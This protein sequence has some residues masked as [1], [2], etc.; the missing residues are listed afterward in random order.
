MKLCHTWNAFYKFD[1]T[2]KFSHYDLGHRT[3]IVL[4]RSTSTHEYINI[5]VIVH[6]RRSYINVLIIVHTPS[7]W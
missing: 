6:E 2:L 3:F 1:L 5:E 4:L 7:P